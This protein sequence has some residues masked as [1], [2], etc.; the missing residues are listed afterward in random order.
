MEKRT[1]IDIMNAD[2]LFYLSIARK[3]QHLNA[4]AKLRLMTFILQAPEVMT[5]EI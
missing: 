5:E 2:D 4:N 1:S 3:S